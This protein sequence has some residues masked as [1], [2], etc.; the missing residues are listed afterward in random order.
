MSSRGKGNRLAKDDKRERG[1]ERVNGFSDAVFA[2]AITLL[3]LTIVVPEVSDSGRLSRE[4]ADMWPKFMGFLISFAIIG[5]FW[6]NHHDMFAYLRRSTTGLLRL[7][8]LLLMFIVLLPFST[9]LM[10]EYG[11][12]VTAVV[13]YDLNMAVVALCMTLLWW[14]ASYRRNLVDESVTPALRKHLLFVYLGMTLVFCLAAALAFVNIPA[15]LYFYFILIPMSIALERM[16]RRESA[17]EDE[18]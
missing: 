18:P 1:V 15:S 4:L 7:N 16:K 13:F 14:Y 2:V 12:S 5:G 10:S 8:L 11:D 6:M 17:Q 9:D 3:I